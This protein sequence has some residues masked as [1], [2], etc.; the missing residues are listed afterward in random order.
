MSAATHSLEA[1][2]N[3]LPDEKARQARS[4]HRGHVSAATHSLEAGSNFPVHKKKSRR[5]SLADSF[6]AKIK[7]RA[8]RAVGTGGTC[9]RRRIPSKPGTISRPIK[10]AR[11][12]RSGH[13]GHAPGIVGKMY[14]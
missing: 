7:K 8:K 6:F 14:G 10:K 9:W 13:R 11:T 1:G 4:G 5:V 2:S 12:A 3:F